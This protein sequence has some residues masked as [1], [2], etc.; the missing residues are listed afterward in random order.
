MSI[1]FQLEDGLERQL[2]R[3]LGDLETAARTALLV[4]AYRQGKLSVGRLAETLGMGALEAEAWL[5]DRGVHLNYEFED[6]ARDRETLRAV[7][8]QSTP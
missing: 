1:T 3:D 6:Y 7:R 5:A 4:E 8:A 2:R